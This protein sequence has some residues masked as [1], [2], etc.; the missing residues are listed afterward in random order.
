VDELWQNLGSADSSV[1]LTS[2]EK[3]VRLGDKSTTFLRKAIRSVPMSTDLTMDKW[4]A[5]LD[6]PDFPLRESASKNLRTNFDLVEEALLRIDERILTL[7][8]QRRIRNVLDGG[9][10]QEK[11]RMLR[12][13]LAL[14]QIPQREA[15]QLLTTLAKGSEQSVITRRAKHVL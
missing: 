11:L 14:E 8:Q 3:L 6:S 12:A 13:I 2:L 15:G 1:A 7:E 5:E 10:N 4:I 9:L